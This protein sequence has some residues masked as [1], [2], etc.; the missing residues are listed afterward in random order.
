MDSLD[1]KRTKLLRAAVQNEPPCVEEARQQLAE[2]LIRRDPARLNDTTFR[3]A[4]LNTL[5]R[6]FHAGTMVLR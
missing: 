5:A 2:E 4:S 6:L 3:I 1:R